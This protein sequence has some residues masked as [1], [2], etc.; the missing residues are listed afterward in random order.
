MEGRQAEYKVTPSIDLA[1][2]NL[3]KIEFSQKLRRL[4]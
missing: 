1:E 2:I 3:E 4:S